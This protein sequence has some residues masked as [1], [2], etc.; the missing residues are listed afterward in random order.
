MGPSQ[1]PPRVARNR[2]AGAGRRRRRGC[3]VDTSS[4]KRVAATPRLP[5]GYNESRRRRGCHVDIPLQHKK[6]R[7]LAGAGR[8]AIIAR[9]EKLPGGGSGAVERHGGVRVG[10]VLVGVNETAT[11]DLPHARVSARAGN[12]AS[13][14]AFARAGRL[15]G[16]VGTA[17]ARRRRDRGRGVAGGATR[18][19]RASRRNLCGDVPERRSWRSSTTRT[20]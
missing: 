19:S 17:A 9:F 14:D 18:D 1:R 6:D 20:S 8:A 13:R 10:D 5:R 2:S 16:S 4:R 11:A 7:A 15:R 3:H 12:R